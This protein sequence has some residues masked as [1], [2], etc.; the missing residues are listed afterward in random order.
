LLPLHSAHPSPETK[1]HL[2]LFSHFRTAHQGVSSG[3]GQ[4]VAQIWRFF[5]LSKLWPSAMLD[6]RN[7]VGRLIYHMLIITVLSYQIS[8]RYVEPLLSNGNLTVFQ[9]GG[10]PPSWILKTEIFNSHYG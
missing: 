6:F 9:N 3:I 4:P 2:D 1:Q 10:Y 5:D 7:L 8:C